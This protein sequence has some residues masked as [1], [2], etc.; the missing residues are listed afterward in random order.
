MLSRPNFTLIN[1][2][3]QIFFSR[4]PMYF[5]F[6]NLAQDRN[7][8]KLDV[9]VNIWRGS[10]PDVADLPELRYLNLKKV[11]PQDNYI[12]I[13][14]ANEINSYIVSG[15]FNK[16][17]P[18]LAYNSTEIVTTANEGVFFQ[19]VY[20]FDSEPDVDLGTCFATTGYKLSND[21][22]E[23]G[24]KDFKD[25]VDFKKYAKGIKYF[26]SSINLNNTDIEATSTASMINKTELTNIV[27]ENQTGVKCLIAYVNS[28]GYW[29]Y[30]TPFGKVT[31]KLNA[32]TEKQNLSFRN[33]YN[34][35][36]SIEHLQSKKVTDTSKL[37]TIN[38][39][40][41]EQ[42]NNYQIEQ[43]LLSQKTYL[44]IFEDEV[45]S[46]LDVTYTVDSTIISVDNT[47]ILV[48]EDTVQL[49]DIGFYKKFQQ[50]PVTLKTDDFVLKTQLNDKSSISY[51]LE[52]ETANDYLM[53]F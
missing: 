50:I 35:N 42:Q 23:F 15:N 10:Q 48:S 27:R 34:F 45:F 53:P 29:D 14:I 11:S 26:E 37:F 17:N 12:E 2:R 6:Q 9:E 33:M 22:T 51:N 41:I 8:T 1:N 39:G 46:D 18:Q 3:N 4:T 31:E 36:A 25:I 21:K 32:K 30:F 43:L 20:K 24:Y 7:F 38:T 13:E 40:L 28:L 19:I 44:I 52:F 5:K 49:G 16:S 47:N